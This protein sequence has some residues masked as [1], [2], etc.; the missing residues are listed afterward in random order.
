VRLDDAAQRLGYEFDRPGRVWVAHGVDDVVG[1][2]EA[3]EAAARSGAWVVGFVT[4]EAARAFDHAF[5]VAAPSATLPLAWM[6]SF[7]RRREVPLAVAPTGGPFVDGVI[8][9]HGSAWYRAGV[10]Q[11][12]RL[13][14]TGDVYQV[15]LTDRIR[16]RLVADPFDLY[17]SMVSTQGG[18]FNAFLD[19]GEAVIASASPELFLQVTGDTVTA[20]PMKGTRR[21]HGRQ[22]PDLLLAEELRRS[23]KDRA[24]N[25]MIV[26][27]L[28]NDL[29]R[30]SSPGGVSVPELFAV[31][32]YET[33]W[34]LT[35]TVR[36]QLRPDVGLAD[37]FRSTFP[38]GSITGAPKVSAMRIIDQ[39]EPTPRGLYCGAIG[40]I[41]PS[42][43]GER[44]SS[45]W[46]VA[47]RTAVI[48]PAT[49]RVEFASGGGITYDSVPADE[50]DELESKV[51]VL[52]SARPAFA[53][54]ETMRL[55]ERGAHNL[56]AHLRR[57]AASAQY[58]GFDCD[59]A[60]IAEQVLALS[61]VAAAQR[62]RIVLDRAGRALLE[63]FPLDDAPATVQLALSAQ[64]VRSD[65]PFLCHKTTRRT[66][67]DRARAANPHADDV[68]L[69]NERGEV[70]ETTVANLLY[71]LG[72]EWYTPPLA[73]GGLPGVGRQLLLDAGEVV[74]RLLPVAELGS[75]A[76]LAVVSSLRGR[77]PAAMLHG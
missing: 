56:P 71:R 38:C 70:V 62:L 10:E 13:I 49:G 42:S 3:A 53:L 63:Q 48:D 15:N 1:V 21:R 50:D 27:L 18:S 25:V 32:R 34:Q 60:A 28:R 58:F 7:A 29:A 35:S 20:R 46:S 77:R 74:E 66:T 54:F 30:L 51:A 31:E 6:C 68:L 12:R 59:P 17:G 9:T 22:G 24:E 73:S 67:Y 69:V 23:E 75:C 16:A 45:I 47:I 72:D 55:D 52:K 19:L 36:A 44:P 2:L 65:D 40:M 61:P 37:V 76:E 11:V 57:L 43:A 33:V 5:P 8:R 26:D 39:L 41:S 4:Y 14:E 64:R